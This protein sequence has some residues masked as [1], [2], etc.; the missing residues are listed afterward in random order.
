MSLTRPVVLVVEDDTGTWNLLRDLLEPAGYAVE[1]APDGASALARLAAGG[2]ELLLLDLMLP[3]LDGLE[4]CRQVRAQPETADLPIIMLTALGSDAQRHA[5]FE[6]GAD[7]YVTKP[8]NVQ[9]LLD[10]VAVWTRTRQRGPAP[11]PLVTA[12][13]VTPTPAVP[14]SG[15]EPGSVAAAPPVPP[16]PAAWCRRMRAALAEQPAQGPEIASLEM[17]ITSC[18]EVDPTPEEFVA[19]LARHV[20]SGRPSIAEAARVLQRAW[21]RERAGAGG[22]DTPPMQETL[23]TL[24]GLLDQAGAQIAC[25]AVAPGSAQVRAYSETRQQR[26]GQRELRQAIGARKAR[27]GEGPPR[28]PT[29]PSRYE[30]ILRAVGVLLDAEPDRAYDLVVTPGKVVVDSPAHG[31]QVFTVDQLAAL[32][33]A[34]VYD[35]KPATQP[36]SPLP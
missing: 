21:W 28:D 25:L 3:D 24:G 27:R 4:L 14:P 2:V 19:L 8:F 18:I 31:S 6:A 29:S 23:R 22:P 11:P 9:E 36:P 13:S 17:L 20:A 1:S 5:G 15:P 32:L 12:A 35:R 10:R 33:Q 16:T 30:T 34:S 7:D 26:L